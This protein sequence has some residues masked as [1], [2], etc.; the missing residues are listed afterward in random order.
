MTIDY[1]AGTF[2]VTGRTETIMVDENTLIWGRLGYSNS[3]GETGGFTP[4]DGGTV[5]ESKYQRFIDTTY[6]FTD[7]EEGDIVEVKAFIVDENTL[8]AAVIK[9]ANCPDKKSVAFT[10][11]LASVDCDLRIVTFDGEN[12]IGA[13]CPGAILLDADGAVMTLCD[14]QPGD[15]VDV[16]GFP[17]ES[18]TLKICEMILQ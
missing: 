14:F 8:L 10:A 13:V 11:P 6:A 3:L 7:L 12:W 4:S 15:P 18:D 1:A 9:V 16:K 2:T 17:M 5:E